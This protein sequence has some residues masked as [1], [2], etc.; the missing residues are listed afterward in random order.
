L[1][2]NSSTY[3]LFFCHFSTPFNLLKTE[4]HKKEVIW[5]IN[6]DEMDHFGQNI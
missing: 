3:Q 2:V 4:F 1:V 5:L 6:I